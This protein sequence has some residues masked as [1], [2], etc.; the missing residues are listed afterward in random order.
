MKKLY[1]FFEILKSILIVLL[2]ACAIAMTVLYFKKTSILQFNSKNDNLASNALNIN[3]GTVKSE[4]FDNQILPEVIS[5]KKPE[6]DSYAIHND[7]G[8]L[9]SIYQI[10]EKNLAIIFSDKSL[11]EK[12]N[13]DIWDEIIKEDSYIYVKFNSELPSSL[14]SMHAVTSTSI[15]SYQYYPNGESPYIY[16]VIFT[17]FSLKKGSIFAYSRDLSGNIYSYSLNE[18]LDENL[19][20]RPDDFDNYIEAK[21]MTK[22]SFL[23]KVDAPITLLASTV[24]FE[25]S[26]EPPRIQENIIDKGL[27]TEAAIYTKLLELFTI[28][29]DKTG[30]YFDEETSSTV[31]IAT[32]GKAAISDKFISYSTEND[33]GGIDISEFIGERSYSRSVADEILAAEIIADSIKEIAPDFFGG[34]AEMLLVDIRKK[35]NELTLEYSYYLDNNSID[36]ACLAGIIKIRNQRLV[37][38]EFNTKSFTYTENDSA[39]KSFDAAWVINIL[40]KEAES[41]TEK[42]SNSKLYSLAYTYSSDSDN[43][44]IMSCNWLP[45]A[46]SKNDIE[47]EDNN[48][49]E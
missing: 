45:I 44:E 11:C 8:Y 46:I 30:N 31:Y 36:S 16:E 48:E 3:T 5:V 17:D 38:L 42:F 34:E 9:L 28:N 29:P 41:S 2:F 26:I 49:M 24:I 32:H 33:N 7:R 35:G 22:A 43:S 23:G 40:T 14:I 37:S 10:S 25:S 47:K 6:G 20:S 39:R 27:S 15:S 21:A 1:S 4:Y 18:D 12:Q 13:D 19:I